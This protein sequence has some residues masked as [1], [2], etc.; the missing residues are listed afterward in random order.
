LTY[1]VTD[2][3]VRTRAEKLKELAD[4]R[5]TFANNVKFGHMTQSAMDQFMKFLSK[6]ITDPPP[7]TVSVQTQ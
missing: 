3:D 5:I 6:K 2:S 7:P 4:S 1:R